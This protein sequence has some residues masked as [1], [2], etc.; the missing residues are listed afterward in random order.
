MSRA[1]RLREID[2]LKSRKGLRHCLQVLLRLFQGP[3]QRIAIR[4]GGRQGGTHRAIQRIRGSTE[5]AVVV[6]GGSGHAEC[7]QRLRNLGERIARHLDRGMVDQRRT[8]RRD[9]RQHE[10]GKLDQALLQGAMDR[11]RV[12]NVVKLRADD[13]HRRSRCMAETR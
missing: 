11:L 1:A 4:I 13:D 8:A 9:P 2:G 3:E 6:G 7:R 12:A 5:M 10:G